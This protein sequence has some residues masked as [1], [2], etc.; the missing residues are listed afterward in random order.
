MVKNVL[1]FPCGSEI[2]FEIYRSLKHSKHFHLFGANSVSDH[3]RFVFEDYI[4]DIPFI[5]EG[6]FILH[7]KRVVKKYNIDYIYPAMDSVITVLKENEEELGCYV[8]ASPKKTT[9]ICLSKKTTYEQ[10]GDV[11]CIP[12]EYKLESDKAFPVFCKP[13]IGY[14]SREVKIVKN[15]E[16]LEAHLREYPDAMILEYLPGAEYTIDCF[17]DKD[18]VLLFCGTRV[19]CRILNG[20][21][22]NTVNVKEDVIFKNIA[23]KIN[24][25]IEFRGAW[26]IQLKRRNNGELVLLEISSRLG[27]SSAL[28]RARGINFAELSLFDA[29]DVPVSIIDNG[30]NVEMDR[31]LDNCF[32]LD[33]DYEEV[34]IDYD[35]T[36]ILNNCEYNL[37]AI[38]FLYYCKNK[39]T[40]ITLLT[41]HE[42][43]LEKSLKY[44]Q[45]INFFDRVIHITQKDNKAKYIDNKNS[46]FIDDSFIERKNVWEQIH[47]PVFSIDMIECLMQ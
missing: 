45:L 8:I 30:Y 39:K 16:M 7:M 27:G 33:L 32:K 46:I 34:F 31:A 11:V 40:K 37:E 21:S 44:F 35:D 3:G 25:A 28:Y 36:I 19:R 1:V 43:D 29:M 15:Q 12:Q 18:R 14:G 42:G 38:K 17:T 6:Q 10:L 41:M 23:E 2:A 5:S 47:I 22:V 9:Q 26:F 20:I 4:S 13:S 24:S